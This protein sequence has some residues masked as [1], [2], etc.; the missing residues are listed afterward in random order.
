[1]TLKLGR[2]VSFGC[3]HGMCTD[4]EEAKFSTL[5]GKV[6]PKT[7]L[8]S[9]VLLLKASGGENVTFRKQRRNCLVD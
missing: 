8:S 1:M 3:L 4:A 9:S 7:H 6:R 5:F 2:D